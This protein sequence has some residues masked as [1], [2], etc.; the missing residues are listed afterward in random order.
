ML[1]IIGI[2]GAQP[3]SARVRVYDRD[4][5]KAVL[6]SDGEETVELA[7][8]ITVREA[9]VVRGEKTVTGPGTIKRAVAE[10]SAF[11]GSLFRVSSGSLKLTNIVIDGRGDDGVL[12]GNLYGWLIEISGG[13]V[14]I[15]DGAVLK[16][17]R[18]TTRASDGGGAVKIR[19]GG[20]CVLEGGSITGN[21]C[22]TGG[23]GVHVDSGGVFYMKSGTI[24]NNTVVGKGAEE[25]FDGR[26]G[27]VY[28][29][30]T[31]G[32]YGGSITS[33]R[34]RGYRYYGGA[35]GGVANAGD[36]VITGTE[37]SSNSGTKGS[38]IAALRGKLT[39]D[40]VLNAGEIWLKES[41]VI[42]TG[43]SF[44]TSKPVRIEP[45]SIREGVALVR[46]LRV[47]GWK[48][49]FSLTGEVNKK[50]LTGKVSDGCLMLVRLSTPTPRPT[51]VP[52]YGGHGGSS[53]GGASTGGG[54]SGP[55][56]NTPGATPARTLRPVPTYI[57]VATLDPYAEIQLATL[58]P[59]YA[60]RSMTPLPTMRYRPYAIPVITPMPTPVPMTPLPTM[61]NK[62]YSIP[63]DT[64]HID[65]AFSLE[66]AVSGSSSPIPSSV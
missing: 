66:P 43:A 65:S 1:L 41:Q 54:Y 57:P 60:P 34:V 44:G 61:P 63:T 9:L 18:N 28:N 4:E 19:S 59:T 6:R 62:P 8:T 52:S 46:G 11:G 45:E 15:C 35:G 48:T 53:G 64:P 10:N 24:S 50:G 25:G 26:G 32:L 17:N 2:G 55:G 13:V 33:N 37:I 30:G 27:G 42:Y 58:T 22:I 14:R 36:M 31:A 38:D 23:A 29:R 39:C 20:T 56:G 5:L 49:W 47:R 40:G 7:K 21:A 3:S 12:A 51:P 16:N